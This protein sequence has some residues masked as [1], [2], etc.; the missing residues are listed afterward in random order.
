MVDQLVAA[1]GI[2]GPRPLALV[3]SHEATR[4][5][6]PA[7][8]VEV[9]R[10]LALD[11]WRVE[12]VLRAD[13]PLRPRLADVAARL[14]VEPLPRARALLRRSPRLRS[15]ANRLDE[16]VAS[17]LLDRIRPDLVWANTVLAAGYARPARARQIPVVV[18]VHEL[19]RFVPRVLGRYD[20]LPAADPDGTATPPR[21]PTSGTGITWVAA[22]AEAAAELAAS[23]LAGATVVESAV[24]V[25]AVQRRADLDDPVPP[26]PPEPRR[27]AL[28]GAC[29][30]ADERKGVD[31][32]L[33]VAA[34]V[35]AHRSASRFVWIGEPRPEDRS[36]LDREGLAAYVHFT[37]ELP[38]PAPTLAQLDVFTL[39]SRLDTFPLVVLEAMALGRPV[40][41]FDTGG[42][43]RQ[44]GD[45][46]VLVAPGDV[47]AF[48]AA[49]EHLLD[50]P[51]RARALGEAARAR[52][53][54]EFDIAVFHRRVGAVAA[55][56][57]R[58]P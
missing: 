27:T 16:R 52:V 56:A 35:H 1:Y 33:D 43:R 22:S 15:L 4:T 7:V 2:D 50:E 44:L 3:V 17:R 18:H 25:A 57:A 38:D 5:G 23:G 36:T 10:G 9:A 39:P 32:W 6:A 8:A 54:A 29:G 24:D 13:G 58:V 51:D 14:V 49:V 42:V 28:V 55:A 37:G 11:G 31:L 34:R 53:A 26:E 46:G 19:S 41:A 30:R 48:A 40:V 12:V 45:A 20:L 47:A 21:D